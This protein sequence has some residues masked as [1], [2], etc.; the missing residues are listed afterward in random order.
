MTAYS[1]KLQ[2]L[3][4]AIC[5]FGSELGFGATQDEGVAVQY[6][7]LPSKNNDS[8]VLIVDD[9]IAIG[10]AHGDLKENTTAELT[11]GVVNVQPYNG[12]SDRRRVRH[13]SFRV[14]AADQ[15]KKH[16]MLAPS[17]TA[18]IFWFGFCHGSA[19]DDGPL[20]DEDAPANI[21]FLAV[22]YAAF[23]DFLIKI[24]TTKQKPLNL[25]VHIEGVLRNQSLSIGEL[26]IYDLQRFPHQA[27]AECFDSYDKNDPDFKSNLCIESCFLDK[28]NDIWSMIESMKKAKDM[29]AD[30]D[31]ASLRVQFVGL[32]EATADRTAAGIDIFILDEMKRGILGTQVDAEE[33]HILRTGSAHIPVVYHCLTSFD[34]SVTGE[35]LLR[36]DT[37]TPE[38]MDAFIRIYN[39]VSASFFTRESPEETDNQIFQLQEVQFQPSVRVVLPDAEIESLLME[40]LKRISL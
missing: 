28:A 24:I 40:L 13:D 9:K 39:S 29:L 34:S 10:S 1:L 22:Q 33:S 25:T 2:S 3:L 35:S 23:Y 20:W 27:I 17:L 21:A 37:S 11:S 14:I 18:S 8:G 36:E 12:K 30:S 7:V 5:L 16:H 26:I 19:T 15:D 32:E 38:R 4:C 6:P 31:A